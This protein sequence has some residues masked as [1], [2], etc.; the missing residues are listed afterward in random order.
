MGPGR[1]WLCPVIAQALCGAFHLLKERL[2][3]IVEGLAEAMLS[4]IFFAESG[5]WW[6][7]IDP[8]YSER[9][10][11]IHGLSVPQRA[12]TTSASQW[13]G[14]QQRAVAVMYS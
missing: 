1:P 5:C 7:S 6:L 10:R 3:D 4:M 13:H 14:Q 12:V 11:R 9:Q 8:R 2:Q